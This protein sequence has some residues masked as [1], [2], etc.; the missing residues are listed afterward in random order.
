MSI[1]LPLPGGR[2][3]EVAAGLALL[4]GLDDGPGLGPHV[5]RHGELPRVS[6]E[7]LAALAASVNVRGR[8]GAGFPFARKVAGAVESGR[9][10]VVVVNISEG[11]PASLKDATLARVAP[12]LVLDGAVLT[13]RALRTRTVHLVLP[14]DQPSVVSAIERALA[15]RASAPGL[16]ADGVSWTLHEARPRFVAGQSAAVLELMAGRPNLPVTSWQPATESGHRGRP[17]LVSNAETYAHVARVA[18]L[19]P[20]VVPLSATSE[21]AGTTLLTLD[22]DARNSRVLEVPLGTPWV[23]VL[24]PDEL[25][26]PVLLGGYHGTWASAG[27]LLDRLVCRTDLSAHGLTLG[28]GVVLP[29]TEGC[30]VDR[31]RRL[32]SYL[33]SESAGRCGPCVNGLPALAAAMEALHVHGELARGT[34]DPRTEVLRLADLVDRRG[35]CAHPDGTARLAR[36]LLSAFPDEV[37]AH[38]RGR[39]DFDRSGVRRWE[40]PA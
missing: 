25:T 21:E 9:R 34:G 24:S 40:V 32:V 3:V 2:T 1:L 23:R 4:A 31:T 38:L 35:A 16:R 14:G 15:E 29:L 8:G 33:A 28:A 6:A 27:A 13:A 36:S 7:Q 30:P 11:E 26:S 19:G 22:G 37:E 10:R 5:A 18:L 39:C 12:H 20:D 17:T